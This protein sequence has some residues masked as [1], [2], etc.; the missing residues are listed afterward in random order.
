MR[1]GQGLLYREQFFQQAA[2][3]GGFESVGAVGLRFLGIVVDFHEDAINTDGDRRAR[4]KRDV[5]GLTAAGC[6]TTVTGL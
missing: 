1:F 3:M 5:F 6:M 4:K 2:E